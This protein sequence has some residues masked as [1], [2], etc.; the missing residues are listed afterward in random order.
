MWAIDGN[1]ML[2]SWRPWIA[3]FLMKKNAKCIRTSVLP[4]FFDTLF[5]NYNH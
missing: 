5:S 1:V 2:V 4:P 3:H